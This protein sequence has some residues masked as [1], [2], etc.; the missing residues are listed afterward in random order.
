MKCGIIYLFKQHH[1]INGTLFYCFEYFKFIQQY[2]DINFYIVG[3]N[4]DDIKLVKQLFSEKY[5]CNVDDIKTIKRTE[6]YSLKLDVTLVFDVHTFTK[7]KEFFSNNV[8]CYSNDTHGN[9][10]YNNNRNVT[11]Y[12]SYHYQKY[13][14]FSYL[15]LNF[16]IFKKVN[17]TPGVFVSSVNTE[18][19]QN[20][21]D[22]WKK[23]YD[24]PIIVKR[25]Y[26]GKGD[27]FNMI[28]TVHYVHWSLDKNNRIIPEAFFYQKQLI[29]EHRTD[30]I[31]SVNYRYDD[32]TN[33]GLDR[34][35]LTLNDPM[36]QACLK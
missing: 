34:Y 20:N 17:N 19:V 7:C 14:V 22:D 32:I 8:H 12:G 36:V 28:D 29:I 18:Y 9:F 3:A 16:N 26:K 11:Y 1:K 13:D 4:N 35:V 10:Q 15:K 2:A 31:D 33:N 24:K 5:T 25:S 27:I 21:L 30:I 23:R 6:I